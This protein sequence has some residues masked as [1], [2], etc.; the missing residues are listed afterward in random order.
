M[1]IIFTAWLYLVRFLLSPGVRPSVRLSIC[2]VRVLYTD[3]W[4][5]RQT[6]L[7][8]DKWWLLHHSSFWLRALTQVTNFKG[9]PFSAGGGQITRVGKCDFRLKLPFYSETIRD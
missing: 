6:S 1:F 8:K 5:Y 4:R 7:S 9:N 3:G 2:R